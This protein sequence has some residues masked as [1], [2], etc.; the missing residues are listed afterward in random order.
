MNA[1]SPP[2]ARPTTQRTNLGLAAGTLAAFLLA[3]SAC[4]A[5]SE[6]AA[7]ASP[8]SQQA[9][10]DG[11]GV[12]YLQRQWQRLSKQ[13]DRDSLIAAE[14]IAWQMAP[15]PGHAAGHAGSRRRLLGDFGR[16]PLVLFVVALG[17][18]VQ[19]SNC[20]GL[21][22]YDSLIRVAP[23][24][25][26]HWL[27]LPD[28]TPPSTAQLHSAASASVADSHTRELM[29]ILNAALEDGPA[30]GT[31]AGANSQ[32]TAQRLRLD[33]V[34]AVPLPTFAG[35]GSLCR[36]PAEENRADCIELGR[37]LLS[38]QSGAI[39]PRMIGSAMIRRLLKGTPEA[40]V[41]T[42]RR[43]EYVWLS[44]K[45]P[46][47]A[48]S[49][50]AMQRDVATLGEWEAWLRLADRVGSPRTPPAGWEPAD[51]RLMQLWE[52]RKPVAK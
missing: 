38:D 6:T 7:T 10:E 30:P 11:Q 27:L 9:V 21:E 42:E 47:D 34:Q 29:Q 49:D 3:G 5:P 25:A 39:V 33:A 17:C 45:L 51:P 2:H 31:P 36:T 35:I 46:D 28:A 22:D 43:R 12:G 15:A 32:N 52:D 20:S 26:V 48:R 41:A 13:T 24:N 4:A 40:A 8:L 50:E 18:Q 1:S 37:K 44:E 16:D 19:C 23:D 14:L